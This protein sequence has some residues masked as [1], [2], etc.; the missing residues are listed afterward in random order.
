MQT[1]FKKLDSAN[2]QIKAL[3]TKDT[4]EA[5]IEK[6]AKDLSR[7]VNIAGFRKGK[8][9][10]SAVKKHYGSKLVQDAESQAL[11][12]LLDDGLKQMKIDSSSLI[13]E[14][15]IAQYDKKDQDIEVEIRVAMKPSID[16]GNYQELV[17]PAV[18]PTIT[19]E[20][21]TKRIEQIASSKASLVD[22]SKPRAVESG[23]SVTIDFKGFLDGEPFAGGEASEFV[24]EIGSNQFIPGFE[25]SVIGMKIGESKSIDVTFP[26]EYGSADLAGKDVKFDV[27]LHKIQVKEDVKIDDK[28]AKSLLTDEDDATVAKL[29]AKVKEQLESEEL[30]KLY[31]ESLKPELLE[32]I[33][34]KYS[35]DLPEFV[36]EQEIDVAL[37]NKAR[38]LSEDE[39]TKLK[40]DSE[41]IKQMRDE[42]RAEAERS[43][44]ATF[45]IDALAKAEDVSI[46][47]QEVM[48]TIYYEAMQSGQDPQKS[49]EQYKES[50]YLPAI[51]MSMVEDRVLTKLLDDKLK[52]V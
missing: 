45:I 21:V 13:G 30:T 10:V 28:L 36:V 11:R 8:T 46:G 35:V 29:E 38:E 47:E 7:Q 25:D 18:K 12:D 49:Y 4:L 9:P 2:A 37:N 6:I 16:L 26:Q 17:K 23:D 24:L 51:Q 14:P 50:G 5:N 32:S 52:S 33:V 27:K 42:L 43:V 41:K 48:Q 34:D 1:T 44:K 22:I 19:D 15:H 31:N 3:I 39:L 20:D 40:E